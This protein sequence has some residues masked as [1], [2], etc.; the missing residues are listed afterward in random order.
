MINSSSSSS[1]SHQTSSSTINSSPSSSLQTSS[2][3][4]IRS[5]SDELDFDEEMQI[6]ELLALQE[7]VVAAEAV[8]SALED[9]DEG[10]SG[11]DRFS[12]SDAWGRCL[13]CF[14]TAY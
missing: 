8:L 11:K 10:E 9:E 12:I 14:K 7:G 3:V 5:S 1:S 4:T 13:S 2:S 6:R